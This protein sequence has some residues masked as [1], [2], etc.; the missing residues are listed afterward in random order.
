MSIPGSTVN[1]P[2]LPKI[3]G[4]GGIKINHGQYPLGDTISYDS[5]PTITTSDR[6]GLNS[7]ISGLGVVTLEPNGFLLIGSVN[8]ES[9]RLSILLA[10]CSSSAQQIT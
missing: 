2:L 8:A 10:K 3:Q 6:C 5:I 7:Y 1:L 4:L 9:T